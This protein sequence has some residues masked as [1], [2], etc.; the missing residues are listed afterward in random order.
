VLYAKL[1]SC[2]QSVLD[3]QGRRVAV[4]R[5]SVQQKILQQL[6]QSFDVSPVSVEVESFEEGYVL[7]ESGDAD[8]IAVNRFYGKLHETTYSARPTS[9]LIAPVLVKFA[10]SKR[11]A[12][13]LLGPI[14]HA[15]TT[16]KGDEGSVFHQAFKRWFEPTRRFFLPHW[17]QWLLTT[18]GVIVF[19][20]I[21]LALR[22][23]VKRKTVELEK[24]KSYLEKLSYFDPLT[25]LP[26]RV[27]LVDRLEQIVRRPRED[28]PRLAVLFIDLDEFKQINDS[29][30]HEV[31]NA[32]LGEVA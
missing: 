23:I 20:S 13:A 25:G 2:I 3:L 14:D 22:S 1:G 9:I 7:V 32:V 17:L 30:G 8:G 11:A 19:A 29:M 27:L 15:L 6:T 26:N 4:L 31:G 16:M 18:I 21:S 24:N 5:D 28:L 12:A 10:A